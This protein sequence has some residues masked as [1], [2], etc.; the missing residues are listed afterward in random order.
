MN[1]CTDQQR[2]SFIK[3]FQNL[4]DE[5]IEPESEDI[6]NTKLAY[7]ELEYQIRDTLERLQALGLD[8]GLS[9]IDLYE[10]D[11]VLPLRRHIEQREKPWL[12]DKLT[13]ALMGHFSTGKTSAM[14]CYFGE[15]FPVSRFET[16]ALATFL[17]EGINPDGKVSIVDKEGGVQKISKEQLKLFSFEGSFNFPFARMFS[18]IVMKSQHPALSKM[19]FVDTP[20]LFSSNLEHSCTA[21]KV[22]DYCDVIFWFVRC[23]DGISDIE[24]S[25]LKERV[26]DKPIYIILSHVDNRGI[27][28]SDV[29][30]ALEGIK[31][32][33]RGKGVE[34]QGYLQ[35]GIKEATQD[36]F[37]KEFEKTIESLEKEHK[38]SPPL[39]KI[40]EFLSTLHEIVIEEQV[41]ATKEKHCK[42]RTL[43]KTMSNIEVASNRFKTALSSVD[44]TFAGVNEIVNTEC[45]H[46]RFCHE[47]FFNLFAK[48]QRLKSC[49]DTV[50]KESKNLDYELVCQCG[51]TWADIRRLDDRISQ[52]ESIKSSIED[53]INSINTY[54]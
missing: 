35:F 9:V 13:V 43:G 6:C 51:T 16:T 8:L 38:P 27:T 30:K 48:I 21:H 47:T 18:Y 52:L 46:V 3:A 5:R 31:D 39:S 22:L 32:A 45:N 15:N 7:K 33:L 23:W 41:K 4:L 44:N 17:C 12:Q 34:I 28:G 37:K 19:T 36:Q 29:E 20:G 2:L 26:G 10:H 25:F 24:I 1:E 50:K 40:R 42:E 54:E 49:I 14:N 53:N 11:V